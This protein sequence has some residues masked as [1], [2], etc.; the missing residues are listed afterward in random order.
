[1]LSL[2][3]KIDKSREQRLPIPD[4]DYNQTPEEILREAN[5]KFDY[6]Q[7]VEDWVKPYDYYR[8]LIDNSN[9]SS[10]P[11]YDLIECRPPLPSNSP[12]SNRKLCLN[13]YFDSNR[14]PATVAR[15]ARNGE[16]MVFN[17]T[18]VDGTSNSELKNISV[19]I[20]FDLEKLLTDKL[21]AANQPSN[22]NIKF[23]GSP[24]SPVRNDFKPPSL[25]S[26]EKKD[27]TK[28]VKEQKSSILI[29]EP[30]EEKPIE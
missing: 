21:T 8:L 10:S 26:F 7:Y 13:V 25:A 1:M 19:K 6:P 20:Y 9:N 30:T 14:D 23:S 11:T 15:Y 29:P 24:S 27:E 4:Y 3:V 16:P 12:V 18:S 17:C 28:T 2:K 5:R 22:L